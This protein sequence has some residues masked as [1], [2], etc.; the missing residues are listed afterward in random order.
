MRPHMEQLRTS[1]TRWSEVFK[2]IARANKYIDETAPWA[3]A[4]DM[5]ANGA[6]L[7]T[8]HVQPAGDHPHLRACC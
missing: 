6:R 4:K 3:L 7:A 5:D 1:R 2:V 8:V